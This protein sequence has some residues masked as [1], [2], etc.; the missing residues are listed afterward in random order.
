MINK[1]QERKEGLETS[2][3]FPSDGPNT[4]GYYSNTLIS[5]DKGKSKAYNPD[6]TKN[7]SLATL[8]KTSL[9]NPKEKFV[10]HVQVIMTIRDQ[11]RRL[12]LDISTISPDCYYNI[13]CHHRNALLP[14][15]GSNKVPKPDLNMASKSNI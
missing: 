5:S 15:E 4:M 12:G 13:I 2:R 6:H 3:V 10:C 1:Y 7:I 8:D 11:G 9:V 14:D